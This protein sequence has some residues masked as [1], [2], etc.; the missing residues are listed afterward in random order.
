VEAYR[1]VWR[2]LC[3]A[4]VVLGVVVGVVVLP[5]AA[6]ILSGFLAVVLAALLAIGADADTGIRQP[7]AHAAAW[8]AAAG[9]GLV[10]LLA[11]AV[12]LGTGVFIPVIVVCVTAPPAVGWYAAL[13]GIRRTGRKE[14]A[15][16]GTTELC[17]Q[18]LDSYDVLRNAGSDQQ[19]LRIV[20]DRQRYLDELE[21]R[22]PE[23]F[24]AWL[25]SAAGPA[26]DPRRFLTDH[27]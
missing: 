22:D 7:P 2:A 16:A 6:W 14:I 5:A 1:R 20:T 27:G 12:L 4:L 15:R 3:G 25:A 23:G 10:A 9:G 24:Q 18:W 13:A 21:R 17:R 11:F 26:T 8:G 19:R